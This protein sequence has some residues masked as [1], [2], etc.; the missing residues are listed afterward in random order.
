[1]LSIAK[2]IKSAAKRNG[3]TLYAVAAR[4]GINHINLSKKIYGNITIEGLQKIA[5]AIGVPLA[6]LVT[7]VPA[8]AP[9][10]RPDP[11]TRQQ[12]TPPAPKRKRGRP[13]KNPDPVQGP[14]LF[15]MIEPKFVCPHCGKVLKITVE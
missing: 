12:M 6:E 9:A 4:L 13:K 11:Q 15:D 10:S 5:D 7:G 14:T 3:L 8:P 2:N 1:M